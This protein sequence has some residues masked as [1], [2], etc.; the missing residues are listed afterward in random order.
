MILDVL[1]E[2]FENL[3]FMQNYS[4]Q[5]RLQS[6]ITILKSIGKVIEQRIFGYTWLNNKMRA[7][8]SFS[9]VKSNLLFNSNLMYSSNAYTLIVI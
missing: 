1:D 5:Q 3:K 9:N 6:F 2:K 4:S 7:I 8:K